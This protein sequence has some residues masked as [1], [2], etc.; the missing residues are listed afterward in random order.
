MSTITKVAINKILYYV[1]SGAIVLDYKPV[2]CAGSEYFI[3]PLPKYRKH[4]YVLL[5]YVEG[6]SIYILECKRKQLEN[7]H[8][9]FEESIMKSLFVFKNIY[10][11]ETCGCG[12]SILIKE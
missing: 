1:P 6:V 3:E 5:N 12:K 9:D 11:E 7:I 8:I 10:P 2:G 4:E